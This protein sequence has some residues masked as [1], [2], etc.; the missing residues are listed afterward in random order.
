MTCTFNHEYHSRELQVEY[1]VALVLAPSPAASD[2]TLTVRCE[3]DE[4]GTKRA[5]GVLATANPCPSSRLRGAL[6]THHPEILLCFDPRR[7]ARG[8]WGNKKW[9]VSKK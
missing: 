5:F 9:I 8:Q 2:P 4:Q 1:L 6:K 3:R 7:V